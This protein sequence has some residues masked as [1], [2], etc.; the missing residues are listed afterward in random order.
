[1]PLFIGKKCCGENDK[2]SK[3]FYMTFCLPQT[4]N[5]EFLTMFMKIPNACLFWSPSCSSGF[6][7]LLMNVC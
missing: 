2:N 4:Q 7:Y 6:V 1:M 3:F 5:H